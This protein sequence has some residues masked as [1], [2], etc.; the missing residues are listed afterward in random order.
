MVSG[1]IGGQPRAET[2][3]HGG[4]MSG[5]KIVHIDMDAFHASVEQRVNPELRGKDHVLS[6]FKR[7]VI[8]QACQRPRKVR[9]GL[10]K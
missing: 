10:D 4:R 6:G 9:Q 7:G 3:Y 2:A 5:R 8:D 1:L